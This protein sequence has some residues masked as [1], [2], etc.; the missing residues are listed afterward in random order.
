MSIIDIISAYLYYAALKPVIS[1]YLIM[2][3]YTAILRYTFI[4]AVLYCQDDFSK[5]SMCLA[6]FIVL[7]LKTVVLLR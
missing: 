7:H 2:I 5:R 3:L 4:I 6:E 1:I